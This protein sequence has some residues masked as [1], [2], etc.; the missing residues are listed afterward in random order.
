MVKYRFLTDEELIELEVEFK[1]FLITNG[2]HDDE[3]RTLNRDNPTKAKEVV[4]MFSD[5]I[6]DKVFTQTKYLHHHSNDK[7]KIFHFTASKA[8]MIGLDFEGENFIPE[9]GLMDFI[10]NN[11]SKFKIYKASKDYDKDLRN[12]EI[13]ALV[14][15]GAGKVDEKWFR[16]FSE[17]T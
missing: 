6:L 1:Q 13:Y 8:V 2:L 16:F 7:I 3:W 12:K 11:I 4:G 10:G 9:E 5:V 15:N 14:R 17:L